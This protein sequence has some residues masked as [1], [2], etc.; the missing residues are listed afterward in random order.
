MELHSALKSPNPEEFLSSLPVH[1][2][3]TCNGL[4]HYAALGGDIHGARQVNLDVADRPADVYTHV[5]DMVLKRLEI[6]AE[7]GDEKAKM[8]IGKVAR[9]VVKQTA[10]ISNVYFSQLN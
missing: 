8:L 7:K 4:Q 3:G 5:A 2:D 10:S 1:Q 9:K 6:D